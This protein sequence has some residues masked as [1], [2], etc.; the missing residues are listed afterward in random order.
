MVLLLRNLEFEGQRLEA[1]SRGRGA[2][3]NKHEGAGGHARHRE[4]GGRHP[5]IATAMAPGR[6]GHGNFHGHF[7]YFV[8]GR[9]IFFGTFGLTNGHWFHPPLGR[10]LTCLRRALASTLRMSGTARFLVS[11][12]D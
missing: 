7:A 6:R 2:A 8:G 4:K 9:Q 12:F 11:G 3:V 1:D 10:G 5:A